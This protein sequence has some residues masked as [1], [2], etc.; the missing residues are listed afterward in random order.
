MV[1]LQIVPGAFSGF[2][3]CS[4]AGEASVDFPAIHNAPTLSAKDVVPVHIQWA[5][6]SAAAL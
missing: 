1:D 5:Y 2:Q 4:R 3:L 6:N